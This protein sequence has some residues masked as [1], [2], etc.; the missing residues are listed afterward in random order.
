MRPSR[1]T[2]A[3]CTIALGVV[4]PLH[5]DD[6][7]SGAGEAPGR[8]RVDRA[9]FAALTP[10]RPL[11]VACT[12]P[13]TGEPILLELERFVA[14]APDA[15][16][17]VV[18]GLGLREADIDPS[19]VVLMR[20]RIPERPGSHA[21]LALGPTLAIGRIELGPGAGGWD[22]APDPDAPTAAD[23]ST[24]LRATPRGSGGGAS[25]ACL[26]ALGD[27]RPP[28]PRAA[29]SRSTG[30]PTTGRVRRIR[31][32]V[33]T[34]YELFELFGDA[35]RAAEYVVALYGAVTDIYLRDAESGF[36]LTYL[37]IWETPEDLFNEP[38]PMGPFRD[39]WNENMADVP[40]DV[41][42]LFSG[43]RDL[44]AG[45][46]ASLNTL[47]TI[48]QAYSWAGYAYGFLGDD[49]ERPSVFHRD[50]T[51]T[52]HELGHNVAALHTHDYGIDTC[53]DQGSTPRR[54][55]IMSYCAQAFSGGHANA[56][57]RFHGQVREIL[58]AAVAADDCL[59][60]DCNVNGIDDRTDVAEGTSADADGDGVPDEC[61]DCD[62]NGVLDAIDLAAGAADVD[63]NGVPDVCEP[64]CNGNGVPDARDLLPSFDAAFADDFERDLGWVAVNLGATSGDWERA[65]PVDDPTSPIDPDRDG[66]G[67]GSCWVTGAGPAAP[68]IGGAVE[69]YS[70]VIALGDGP[71]ELSWHWYLDGKAG[72]SGTLGVAVSRV[73]S[74]L[75]VEIGLRDL[76]GALGWRHATADDGLLGAA[77]IGPG[78]AVR[79]R[80]TARTVSGAIEA[81]FDGVAIGRVV[82][83]VGSD[84]FGDG[85]L[86]DCEPDCDGDGVPDYEA[87]VLDMSRDL[88]RDVVPDDC[89]DCDGDGVPDLDAL[90]G[91]HAAWIAGKG[92][93]SLRQYLWRTGTFVK[94]G[95]P[96]IF[97]TV[98]DLVVAGTRVLASIEEQDAVLAFA[99]DGTHIGPLVDVG[100]G[101][102]DA[103]AGLLVTPA[104]ELLVASR[105]TDSVLRYALSNGAFLGAL[106]APGAGGLVAPFGLAIDPSDGELYVTSDDGRVL[107]FDATTGA[108]L[109]DFV[110]LDRNAGLA[111]PRGMAFLPD[112]DLLVASYGTAEVLRWQASS[113][114]PLGRFNRNGTATVMTLDRPWSIRIGPDGGVYVSRTNEPSAHPHDDHEQGVGAINELHLHLTNARVFHFDA[115]LG[116]MQRAYVQGVD[117]GIL[118]PTA[119]VFLPGDD[120]DC[121]GNLVPDACDVARGTSRDADGDG[122]PDECQASACAADVDG[123]GQVGFVDLV[124]VLDAWGDCDGC[125][126]DLD[127]SG[128]VGLADLVLLL[129]AWGPCG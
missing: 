3:A 84:L 74:G 37:R 25:V 38:N 11:R 42:Q 92:E 24:T 58:R 99:F 89:A 76:D 56:D 47:C 45:G 2:I 55:T 101:G 71:L 123:D 50:L 52:A 31:L 40:R 32:A 119:F 126:T 80:V 70:P 15:R 36:L 8:F 28:T 16:L 102:L 54:G 127:G 57:L 107:R 34:D 1:S 104:G 85:V 124:R 93:S 22:L 100:V 114:T 88:D 94:E 72:A 90:D 10:G 39:Y 64:D 44:P 17:V 116:N 106:V 66:D 26:G 75:W 7:V 87:I 61:Q 96:Q 113:G 81:A 109:G 108:A 86:D 122:I 19:D 120:R 41:A 5:A 97:G 49:L 128:D 73:G 115:T 12:S 20:G 95:D 29:E 9:A 33:E 62:G 59:F 68:L 91:A 110:P 48:G 4:L 30:I 65:V 83:P 21:F 6:A 53:N 103:P 14:V 118:H 98:N 129:A 111:Q 117:S 77:G 18:G 27:P 112:G 63:G 43:R 46:Q 78:D 82:P 69:L 125:S 51:V 79:I 121:N 67:S 60:D 105:G 13:A 23:G 35:D